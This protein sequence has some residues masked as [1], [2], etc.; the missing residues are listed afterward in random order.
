MADARTPFGLTLLPT[1]LRAPA[2]DQRGTTD[3]ATAERFGIARWLHRDDSRVSP[4]RSDGSV[5][6]RQSSIRGDRLSVVIGD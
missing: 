6:E 1:T 5:N 4:V 3:R 2:L